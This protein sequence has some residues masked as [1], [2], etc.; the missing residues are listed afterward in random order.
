MYKNKWAF[1]IAFSIKK[2]FWM[3]WKIFQYSFISGIF[4]STQ[5]MNN[6]ISFLLVNSIKDGYLSLVNELNKEYFSTDEN[7]GL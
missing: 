2:I 4:L 1:D 5:F 6:H 7:L 3:V